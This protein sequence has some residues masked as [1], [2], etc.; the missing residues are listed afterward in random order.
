MIIVLEIIFTRWWSSLHCVQRNDHH[1][2]KMI[3]GMMIIFTSWWLWWERQWKIMAKKINRVLQFFQNSIDSTFKR[4]QPFKIAQSRGGSLA[5]LWYSRRCSSLITNIALKAPN[6]WAA[7]P[8]W[9]QLGR[10]RSGRHVCHPTG[11]TIMCLPCRKPTSV[12]ATKS[13]SGA[14]RL[15]VSSLSL[16]YPCSQAW[17]V[18][19]QLDQRHQ[20]L[21]LIDLTKKKKTQEDQQKQSHSQRH[22]RRS[23]FSLP[24]HLIL[25]SLSLQL[26][27]SNHNNHHCSVSTLEL[28][29]SPN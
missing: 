2:V 11:V 15:R 3:S 26:S 9:L 13:D 23:F 1:L 8:D 7:P 25:V 6:S 22:R 5:R 28:G 12:T 17:N 18:L 21:L 14:A 20:T 27:P 16:T 10:K 29:L 19:Q 24:S 4:L